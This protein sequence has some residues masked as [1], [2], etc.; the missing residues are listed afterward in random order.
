MAVMLSLAAAAVIVRSTGPV[1]WHGVA[2][3]AAALVAVP[4]LQYAFGMVMFSG[5][6]WVSTTYLVGFLLALLIGARWER[7]SPGQ[8]ADGLFFAVGVGAILSVGLQLHQWFALDLLDIWSMGN[9]Y[10]R[11][12]A[13]LGQPNQLGT[14]L[15]WGILA[16][17]WGLVR[18]R[19]GAGTALLAVGYLLFGVAL[20][21]SRT[22]WLGLAILICASWFW[23]HLWPDR[24]WPWV[25]T[26]LSV[27]FAVCVML[28]AWLN[29]TGDPA[30]ISGEPRPVI[31]SLF[32]DAALRHP[33][34]GYGW[35]Q[36]GLA[37]MTAAPD[38]PSLHNFFS[39]SHNLFLDLILWC[40]IPI[41]LFVSIYLIRWLWLRAR[42][43][44]GAED[45]VLLLF[46][47]V[48]GNH[49][50]F[51]FPL[52]YA[53]FLLPVGLVMGALNAR[54]ETRPA[55]TLGRWSVVAIWFISV[56]LLGLIIRD[57]SRVETSYQN[58]RFEWAHIE[59]K[60]HGDLPD[61]L[62]L[63]QWRDFI[64]VARMEPTSG[65]SIDDL[66]LMRNITS[67]YPSALAFYKLAGA[68]ALNERP[69][70]AQLWLK[71]MCKIVPESECV[72]IKAGWAHQSLRYPSIAAV[73]WPN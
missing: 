40:G 43:V 35:S 3:L 68:L 45:A 10:G 18:R 46:L 63:T 58:L 62:L 12:F 36:V 73:P 51:E 1:R 6:A 13:N 59:T 37:D 24:R 9:G 44:R 64:R 15:L 17:A 42:A 11:P 27:Y 38:H 56:A 7:A 32:V 53:Y 49:A 23:R 20:T 39:H 55:L 67:I 5:T 70:E 26:G 48:V 52:H 57:Y 34:F 69:A 47:F 22:A 2:I 33:I 61:V 30:R 4:G 41:G 25:A 29:G 31:W 71:R 14:L 50:M 8:L 19:I 60:T 72:G 65:M 54:L 16:M 21:E 66:D 28:V